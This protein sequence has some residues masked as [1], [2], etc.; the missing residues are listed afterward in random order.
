M[1]VSERMGGEG[2]E[3]ARSFAVQR[4]ESAAATMGGRLTSSSL[5]DK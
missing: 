4:P 5:A 2:F 3:P 1:D